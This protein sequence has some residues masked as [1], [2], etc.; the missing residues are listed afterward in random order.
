[1]PRVNP[2]PLER[3]LPPE[4]YAEIDAY[5]DELDIDLDSARRKDTLI[6]VLHKAQ[7]VFG[8]LP[9]EVQLHIANR[10]AIGHAEVSGVISFYNYF[11]T[12]PKG[13]VQISV[14]MGTACYVNGA[15]KI[16]Q[17][18]EHVLGILG[19]HCRNGILLVYC[20]GLAVGLQGFVPVAEPVMNATQNSERRCA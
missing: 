16:L 11:T 9:E 13:K 19:Q 20:Q 6:Q 8:F 4:L 12:I 3:V 10:Y 15:E 1:M 18:F 5:I 17:E 2:E 7:G 14:C